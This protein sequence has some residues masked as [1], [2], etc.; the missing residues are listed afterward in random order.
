[1]TI[2]LD[3]SVFFSLL[4]ADDDRHS[5]AADVWSRLAGRTETLLTHNYVLVEASA[6][7]QRRLGVEAMRAFLETIVPLLTV[8][9]VDETMHAAAVG[10][11]LTSGKRGLS[12][13]D[14]ISFEV[15]R[16]A[17]L[18]VYFAFDAHF[19]EMGFEAFEG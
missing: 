13:V 10:A 17:G 8:V 18:R 14:C 7:I 15:M 12:L 4:D 19:A 11:L 1:M 2:F 9:W 5:L 16:R 6:L 3:T